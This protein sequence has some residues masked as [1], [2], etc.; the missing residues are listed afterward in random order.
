M[1][2]M[3]LPVILLLLAVV[4]AAASSS[5]QGPAKVGRFSETPLG[6][7][8][9]NFNLCGKSGTAPNYN[10]AA[11]LPFANKPACCT[12]ALGIKA[13]WDVGSILLDK[14]GSCT[15][16]CPFGYL[17][18]SGVC[19]DP[20][21]NNNNCGFCGCVCPGN[22][23]C[24]FG[25]CGYAKVWSVS[26]QLQSVSWAYMIY[27]CVNGYYCLLICTCWFMC[28]Y[29]RLPDQGWWCTLILWSAVWNHRNKDC[30]LLISFWSSGCIIVCLF[31][32]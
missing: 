14:C 10:C 30:C 26:F 6:R 21:T 24:R 29:D 13:C 2:H 16:R 17:C 32:W 27:W 12:D 9:L 8:L 1:A 5:D 25:L 28:T 18:C 11:I 3:V 20:L 31:N 22:L 23:S 4:S 7:K 19:V 15:T